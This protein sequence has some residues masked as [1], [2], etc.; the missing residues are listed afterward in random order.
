[1]DFL[2]IINC[3]DTRAKFGNNNQSSTLLIIVFF[4]NFL[5]FSLQ[6][7]SIKNKLQHTESVKKTLEKSN[8]FWMITTKKALVLI[9]D[10]QS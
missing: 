1:M 10:F 2:S 6:K 8:A 7:L 9:N 5:F 4:T 3:S